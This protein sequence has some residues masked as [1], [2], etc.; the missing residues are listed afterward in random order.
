VWNEQYYS[1]SNNEGAV[2]LWYQ[3][4]N[5]GHRLYATVG[6][7]IHGPVDPAIE[8]GFVVVYAREFAESAILDAV[9]QG[10]HYLST[11]PTLTFTGQAAS[12]AAGMMG[13]TLPAGE[14]ELAVQWGACREGDTLRL[15]ADGRVK[16]ERAVSASGEQ[17][18][19]LDAGAAR[20]CVVEVRDAK[21]NM[22][23]LTNP[24]FVGSA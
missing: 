3:W 20:W 24:I 15:I 18:W 23:A 12:G 1:N 9:R 17:T 19:T 7:D 10:H 22:R 6:T 21:G 13:D 14:C 11:G 5:Q 16:D 8:F 4:L 2:E